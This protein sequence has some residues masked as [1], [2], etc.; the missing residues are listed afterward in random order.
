MTQEEYRKEYDAIRQDYRMRIRRLERIALEENSQFKL[1]DRIEDETGRRIRVDKIE[2]IRA[3]GSECD[4]P[5]VMYVGVGLTRK[6]EPRKDGL[7][8]CIFEKEVGLIRKI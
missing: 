7:T 1:G 8:Y 5:K 2:G 6:G 3:Y 4:M